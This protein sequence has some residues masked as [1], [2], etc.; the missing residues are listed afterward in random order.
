MDRRQNNLERALIGL[1][2]VRVNLVALLR[3]QLKLTARTVF[4][5]VSTNDHT[6]AA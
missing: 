4:S 3:V 5:A 1:Q 6:L 2:A